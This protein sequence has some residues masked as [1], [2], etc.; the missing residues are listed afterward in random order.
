MKLLTKEMTQ[1]C[2][3]G[4][5]FLRTPRLSRVCSSSN[6]GK[7][8]DTCKNI[9]DHF[10]ADAWFMYGQTHLIKKI[11]DQAKVSVESQKREV[12]QFND[13][14]KIQIAPEP[15]QN[16]LLSMPHSLQNSITAILK[17]LL[18]YLFVI[19]GMFKKC[20]ICRLR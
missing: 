9:H 10:E 19:Q 1:L 13:K 7:G 5:F 14:E 17:S 6:N 16:V 15:G 4:V 2:S 18:I 12:C 11:T 8:Q 3:V 20:L